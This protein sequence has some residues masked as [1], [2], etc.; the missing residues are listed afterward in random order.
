MAM[1]VW[2]IRPHFLT[3]EAKRVEI[4]LWIFHPID[5]LLATLKPQNKEQ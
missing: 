3:S 5:L 1:T 4:K 2:P